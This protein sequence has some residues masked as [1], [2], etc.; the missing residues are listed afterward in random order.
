MRYFLV[1]YY[2]QP[3]GQMDEVAAISKSLKQRDL[4]Q[5]S[6]ILD[7]K[8]KSVLKCSWSGQTVPKEWDKIRDYY[9]EHYP[10]YISALE[11]AYTT[12]ETLN[13]KEDN[14]S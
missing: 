12:L 7:F 11:T 2:T 8:T 13:E 5:S 10:N 3:N 14:P 1:T 9:V 4:A 6:I